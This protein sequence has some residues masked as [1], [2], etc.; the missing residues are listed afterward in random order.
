[1]DYV[2]DYL[3]DLSHQYF[4]NNL[5]NCIIGPLFRLSVEIVADESTFPSTCWVIT[6]IQSIHHKHRIDKIVKTNFLAMSSSPQ[7]VQTH[8]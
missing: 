5:Q 1:M 8:L 7:S 2:D 6:I 4:N 3:N